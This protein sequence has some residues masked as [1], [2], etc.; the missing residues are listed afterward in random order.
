MTSVQNVDIVMQQWDAQSVAL[1]IDFMQ[2]YYEC[3]GNVEYKDWTNNVAQF[4]DFAEHYNSTAE[5]P[6]TDG[7]LVDYDPQYPRE[8]LSERQLR[9]F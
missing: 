9:L 1:E 4:D 3:C 7:C 6:V 5:Y 8:T 2:N